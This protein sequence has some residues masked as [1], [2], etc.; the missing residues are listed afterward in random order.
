MQIQALL[1]LDNTFLYDVWH[2][3]SFRFLTQRQDIFCAQVL[4]YWCLVF[5]FPRRLC[6]SSA[7]RL[8]CTLPKGKR[9]SSSGFYFYFVLQRLSTRHI[10][11]F[12]IS[13]SKEVCFEHKRNSQRKGFYFACWHLP[14]YCCLLLLSVVSLF[15]PTRRFFCI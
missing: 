5:S 11:H 12:Y 7:S 10:I 3:Q 2:R 9:S 1:H 6:I 8:F 14:A 15:W 4:F 13:D